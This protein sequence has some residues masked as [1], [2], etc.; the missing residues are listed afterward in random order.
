MPPL[1]EA[2]ILRLRMVRLRHTA[3]YDAT[4]YPLLSTVKRCG[5]DSIPGKK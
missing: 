4:A 1:P 3:A 5:N 2:I